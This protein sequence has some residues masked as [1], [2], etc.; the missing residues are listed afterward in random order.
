MSN[1]SNYKVWQVRLSSFEMNCINENGHGAV[2][3]HVR[4]L[5][6]SMAYDK[7][8]AEKRQMVSEAWFEGDFSHVANV[9]ADSL[10]EVFMLTNGQ[11][12]QFRVRKLG[13]MHSLSVGDVVQ[14]D[15]GKLHLCDN[16]GFVAV[17]YQAGVN[18][19]EL[20]VA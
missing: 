1:R 9:E 15:N 3:K 12:D 16:V 10:E 17:N 2:P 7:T 19:G 4:N 6:L 14:D 13:R 11:G 8:E 5:N 20:E 18:S